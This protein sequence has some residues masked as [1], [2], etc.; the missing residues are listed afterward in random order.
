M[1]SVSSPDLVK[2]VQLLRPHVVSTA[3]CCLQHDLLQLDHL[4]ELNWAYCQSCLTTV[5]YCIFQRLQKC[6]RHVGIVRTLRCSVPHPVC[7]FIPSWSS[8]CSTTVLHPSK[9]VNSSLTVSCTYFNCD[10][11]NRYEIF[12]YIVSSLSA[13]D[14]CSFEKEDCKQ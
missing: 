7:R 4:A 11:P 5:A 9:D 10:I 2:S 13:L 6:P 14:S 1:N 8:T 3:H 12:W